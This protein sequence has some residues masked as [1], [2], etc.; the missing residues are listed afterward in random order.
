[1]ASSDLT[2]QLRFMKKPDSRKARNI[3]T[4]TPIATNSSVLIAVVR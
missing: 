3:F 4:F 2:H 1:M